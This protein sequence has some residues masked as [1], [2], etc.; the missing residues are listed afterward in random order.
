MPDPISSTPET[1]TTPPA[2][3]TP[4]PSQPS[5]TP[6][7]AQTQPSQPQPAQP[8]A[9]T[10][11][12]PAATPPAAPTTPSWLSALRE[13]GVNIE[14]ADENAAIEKLG[15]IYGNYQ[16]LV[17]MAPYVNTYMQN[18]AKFAQWQAEQQRSSQQQPGQQKPWYA[19]FW[20]PPEYNPAWEQMI[21]Q[22][23]QGNFVPVPG[24]PPDVIPKLLAYR[25]FRKEQAE[26]FLSNPA[27]FI[28]P[29]VRHLAKEEAQNLV[30]DQ[31]S[32]RQAQSSSAEFVQQ[33]MNWLY[34]KDPNG[35]VKQ[36][37]VFNPS[38]GGFTAVPQLSQW[39]QAF[40]KYAKEESEY[41]ARAG[42]PQDVERQ[43]QIALAHVQRDYL[44]SQ[45][46]HQQPAAPVAAP[47]N[48]Q[49]AA[50]QQFL[51]AN[52]PPAAIPPTN[53]N[54][55][56]APAKVSRGTFEQQLRK[57]FKQKGI[58]DETLVNDRN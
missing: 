8:G 35:N 15:E 42:L 2:A 58:T 55:V 41:Q 39:G 3:Q 29:I 50:N 45:M 49:A 56:P 46:S 16:K 21:Q 7:P 48:P 30:Q 13:R 52:N 34:E 37:Q 36:T 26:K 32:Q 27:E 12:P 14:A 22:D 33:N 18:A 47:P 4:P 11:T 57:N 44:L 1:P 24:A 9:A 17:P 51:Q 10:Q 5:Q 23:A 19:D 54:T 31:F 6:P 28:A 40:A 25:Q 43:K 20:N 53:G 38:T